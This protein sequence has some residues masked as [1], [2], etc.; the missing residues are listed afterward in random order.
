MN[1]IGLFDILLFKLGLVRRRRNFTMFIHNNGVMTSEDNDTN[2]LESLLLFLTSYLAIKIDGELDARIKMAR[3]QLLTT[4]ILE[5]V[6][7]KL[8]EW[9]Q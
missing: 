1:K 8:E 9:K 3:A 2:V 4:D 5:L 6:A 7:H